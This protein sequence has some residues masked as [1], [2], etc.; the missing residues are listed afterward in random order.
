MA[1]VRRIEQID[2]AIAVEID[3]YFITLLGMN[4]GMPMAPA[5]EPFRRQRIDDGL[6]REQQRR[7]QLAAEEFH[8]LGAGWRFRIS[9]SQRGQRIEHAEAAR[10]AA[11]HGFHADDADD[12]SAGTPYSDSARSSASRSRSRTSRRR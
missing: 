1:S 3:A 11:I 2:L 12:D 6:A 10:V 8:A 9:K 5:N 4:C 7:F